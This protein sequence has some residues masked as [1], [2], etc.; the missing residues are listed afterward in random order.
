MLGRHVEYIQ[1]TGRALEN[2]NTARNLVAMIQARIDTFGASEKK[3]AEVILKDPT[4]FNGVGLAELARFAGV[5]QPTV[6]RFSRKLGFD[7]F[8]DFKVAFAASNAVAPT[9]IHQDILPTDDP[10][11]II[12][13]VASS[14]ILAIAAA[15]DGLDPATI[16]KAADLISNARR[17]EC[18]GNGAAL[19]VAVEAQNK[20]YRLGIPCAVT[21][22]V[23]TQTI[24]AR[25]M[26]P[27]DV[28]LLI[29]FSGAAVSHLEI[30]RLAKQA[31]CTLIAITR[32][33]APLTKLAT[34]SIG[35]DVSED[36]ESFSPIATP[37]TFIVVA[38]AIAMCAAQRVSK[39]VT[40]QHARGKAALAVFN[41]TA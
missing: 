25:S 19:S 18:F 22:D 21:S 28:I 9:A 29:S 35:V 20:I 2:R 27:G 6:I 12:G 33:G 10:Q 7:G 39:D 24:L 3:V 1:L 31:G 11:T 36:F 14:A 34:I 41:Q 8:A 30:G 26:G 32:P 13:K 17:V 37:V 15:R 16:A 5:S 23:F 40:K 4:R 38:D